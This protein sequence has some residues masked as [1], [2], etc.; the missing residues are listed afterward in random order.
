MFK[1]LLV[2]R[3][4]QPADPV[5]FSTALPHWRVG[6]CLMVDPGHHLRIVGISHDLD[7]LDELHERGIDGLWV[8]EPVE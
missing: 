8:V 5:V 7:E 2:L 6:E 1:Y 3:N 4:G